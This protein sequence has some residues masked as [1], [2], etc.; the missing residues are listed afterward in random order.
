MIYCNILIFI[1]QM[2]SL[3]VFSKSNNKL[4]FPHWDQRL[5]VFLTGGGAEKPVIKIML[6]L[7]FEFLDPFIFS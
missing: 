5:Q 6:L 4:Q 3:D 2:Q 1:L 7:G